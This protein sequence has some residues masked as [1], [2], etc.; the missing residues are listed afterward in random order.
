M[1]RTLTGPLHT[2]LLVRELEP[3]VTIKRIM[4]RQA[5]TLDLLSI[6]KPPMKWYVKCYPGSSKYAIQDTGHK[7]Y[8]AVIM[9]GDNLYGVEEEDAS[10]LELEHQFQDFY[11]IKLAGTRRYLEHPNIKLEKN[12]T[13]RHVLIPKGQLHKQSPTPRLFLAIRKD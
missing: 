3:G 10:A 12:H 13:M 8:I 6:I 5:H 7:K 11:L 4:K 1:T 9:N 2:T